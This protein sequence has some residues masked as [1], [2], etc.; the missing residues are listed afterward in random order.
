MNRVSKLPRPDQAKCHCRHYLGELSVHQR[1]N[2]PA[3]SEGTDI[4]RSANDLISSAT[5]S[6]VPK[7]KDLVPQNSV[8]PIARHLR[9]A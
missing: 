6:E 5:P 2:L 8:R 3:N 4:I 7:I 9:L 1:L